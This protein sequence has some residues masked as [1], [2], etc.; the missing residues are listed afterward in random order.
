MPA[1]STGSAQS[2]SLKDIGFG[3][4]AFSAAQAQAFASGGGVAQANAA[5]FAQADGF[6]GD[7][8]A[9]AQ[10]V[11]EARSTHTPLRLDYPSSSYPIYFVPGYWS[12]DYPLVAQAAAEAFAEARSNGIGS[13]ANAVAF[14]IA[15]TVTNRFPWYRG[16]SLWQGRWSVQGSRD[17]PLAHSKTMSALAAMMPSS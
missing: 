16:K 8:Q 13:D 11:A 14:A 5:A 15:N 9:F 2:R 3:N 7:S 6:G 1:L 4:T 10:A 17:P 12:P